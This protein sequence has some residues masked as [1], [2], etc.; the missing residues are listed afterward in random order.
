MDVRVLV[1]AGQA[2]VVV[3]DR[4]RG[5][6]AD[7][8]EKV[9]EKF[10]RVEDPLRMTTGGTGLGLYIARQLAAAMG[11]TLTCTSTLGAGSVFTFSLPVGARTGGRDRGTGTRPGPSGAPAQ[12]DRPQLTAVPDLEATGTTGVPRPRQAPPWA[13]APTP[14]GPPTR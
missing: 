6:P 9:F 13:V 2:Q 5:I 11:G 10:H 14:P 3:E 12:P 1:T 8:L 7:Q 4:G